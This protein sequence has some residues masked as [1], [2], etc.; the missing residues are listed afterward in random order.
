MKRL[1]CVCLSLALLAGICLPIPAGASDD[2][3][4]LA[5]IEAGGLPAGISPD[6]PMWFKET[7]R[8]EWM[9]LA[10][11][12]GDPEGVTA[13]VL[14]SGS[15]G[16][17]GVKTRTLLPGETLRKG[18]DVSVWQGDIDWKAVAR[19]GVEFAIIRV[20][21]RGYGLPGT[22]MTDTKYKQ[23]IQGAQANGI[24]V[25]AYIFSQAITEAE[26][27]EEARYLMNLVSGYTMDLPL[28]IDYEYAGSNSG[29]LYNAGLSKAQATAICNAF[30]DEVESKG[31]DS[32]VYA[33]YSMLS[34][35]L[36]WD[37]LGRVWMAYYGWDSGE[38]DYEYWQFSSSGKV[39]GISGD[40]DLNF[41]LDPG[42]GDG[43]PFRDVSKTAWYY[44]TIKQAYEAGIVKGTSARTFSPAQK[45]TR[46]QLVT[47]FYRMMGSPA[48]SGQS[49]FQDLKADYYRNA[50][51]W[52]WKNQVVKGYSETAF[53]PDDSITRQDLV[54]I[55]YRHAGEPK[56]TGNLLAG[57]SD[58]GS[59]ASYA[60][61]AMEWAMENKILLGSGGKAMPRDSA[62]RA[63]ACTFLMRYRAYMQN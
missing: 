6:D 3:E 18:I 43:F 17:S 50:V 4:I 21:N 34:R 52:A 60:W 30:C 1:L 59:I 42:P 48:I 33:N 46:G 25:G 2:A 51:L 8:E 14:A 45:V 26:G 31:Y 53:G 61:N 24:K 27:R 44:E 22:L 39:S 20:A 10:N 9:A 15:T 49:T 54:T 57:F 5:Q 7:H 62:T 12:E 38:E 63:E 13:P 11:G 23:N 58:Q 36:N 40:V 47:M 28:V 41:W 29:R 55:L 32:M 19:S 56:V 16:F 35:H 37:Q